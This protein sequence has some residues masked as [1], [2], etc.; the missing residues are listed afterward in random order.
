MGKGRTRTHHT[1]HYDNSDNI[2]DIALK[3][4]LLNDA[5]CKSFLAGMQTEHL[6]AADKQVTRKRATSQTPVR[7]LSIR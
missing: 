5:L 7:L 6:L 1:S 2:I 4:V 3:P